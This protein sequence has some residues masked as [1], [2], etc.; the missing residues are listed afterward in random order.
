METFKPRSTFTQS[1]PNLLQNINT[2]LYIYTELH[3]Q[4]ISAPKEFRV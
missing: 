2:V 4:R 3:K 1:N